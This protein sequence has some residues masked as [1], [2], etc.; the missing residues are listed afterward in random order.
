MSP[1]LARFGNVRIPL[2]GGCK[3]GARPIDLHL[4]GF[5]AMGAKNQAG[6]WIC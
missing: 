1:C 6:S 2:P 5:A 4:K 3:I